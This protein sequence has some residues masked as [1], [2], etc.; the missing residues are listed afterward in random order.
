MVSN[1]SNELARGD[2]SP[3]TLTVAA[4]ARR[5]GVAPATLRTWDRR[6]GLGPGTHLAGSH[7]RYSAEDLARLGRPYEQAGDA[8]Q[9]AKGTGLGLSLVQAF[10][11]LHGGQM[12]LESQLGEGTVVSVRM[13][14]VIA[15]ASSVSDS[16]EGPAGGE[17]ADLDIDPTHHVVLK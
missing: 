14:V 5:L 16:E 8:T 15:S 11:Q 10:A 2:V 1:R 7:R 13:P 4:V 6:Y 17:V 12:H 9:R 3:A